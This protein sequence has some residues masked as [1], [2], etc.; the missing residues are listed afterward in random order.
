MQYLTHIFNLSI[1]LAQI[2]D[3]WKKALVLPIPKAGKPPDQGRSYRPI[4]LLCPASKVLERLALPYLNFALPP[5]Q[6]QHG[7]RPMHSTTTALLPL[8]TLVA[9]GFNQPK[10]AHRTAALAIDFAKAF[11]T[12]HHPTLLRKLLDTPLH[13]N[14]TR[15]LFTYLRGRKAACLYQSATSS[16]RILHAGV[17]Q[18]SVISPCLFNFF[19]SDCPTSPP[20]I[21]SY[22]DDVTVAVSCPDISRDVSTLSSRLSDAFGPVEDWAEANRMS[23]APDKSSVTLFTPWSSQV[24]AGPSIQVRGSPVPT[25][26]K[27][28]IL[29]V[30]FDPMF[31]FTP[32]ITDIAARASSRLQVLKALAGTSWG[33]D[34]E[35]ILLTYKAI[36]KPILTYAAPIWFPATCR[37]NIGKLQRI[38]NQALRIATGSLLKSDIQHLHSETSIL[39]L[40]DHLGV[41]CAQF[42]AGALRPA[43]PSHALVTQDPGPRSRIPLLQ[44]TFWSAV[45]G[46]LGDG[47]VADPD[48][49]RF[50][51]SG[52]HTAAVAAH[53]A[54]RDRSKV[55]LRQAPSISLAESALPR[56]YRTT[57][58][59]LRSG[60]CSRLNSYRHAI[61]IADTDRCPGC[62]AAPDTVHHLFSCPAAPTD[63]SV[64]D[65]W[66][67]PVEVAQYIAALP[68]FE[69]LPALEVREPRPPPE[70]P[71][72]V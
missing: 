56:Y 32:H 9:S 19:L 20:L 50:T 7:F 10:P 57:L 5:N 55:L 36:I 18:G 52:I 17:P 27:P 29:G 37:S 8:S 34:K 13:S 43:H 41:L 6:S 63:L 23:I 28:K 54:N 53:L 72:G 15:W 3:L 60:Q 49:H 24:S 64:E 59:Q 31:T 16:Y 40:S 11:D 21:A 58:S 33:Q 30:T 26:R 48:M 62:G 69:S 61:G 4:S 42:L 25:E 47:G 71:P 65:L 12:V 70:P 51:I 44:T 1:S 45:T 14:W 66:S 46:Y 39:P 35:T 67:R 38:Q 68:A 2:P 22:A